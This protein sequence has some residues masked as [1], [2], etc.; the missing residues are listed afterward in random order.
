MI[1]SGCSQVIDP[2]IDFKTVLLLGLLHPS[3]YKTGLKTA[4]N[5]IKQGRA[6]LI[7]L[8]TDMDT[9]ARS[10][11][12]EITRQAMA[13]DIPVVYSLSRHHMVKAALG[14]YDANDGIG[15]ITMC[16]L[17]TLKH[18]SRELLGHILLLAAHARVSYASHVSYLCPPSQLRQ[19]A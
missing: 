17:S 10:D 16:E 15:A 11:V 8:A 13:H 1:T 18:E 2:L 6:K 12:L 14:H 7:F 5:L 3:L 4:I 9:C 19:C